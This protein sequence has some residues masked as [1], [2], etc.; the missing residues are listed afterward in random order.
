VGGLKVGVEPRSRPS[1][2]GTGCC[3]ST[4]V[5]KGTDFGVVTEADAVADELNDRPRK[6]LAFARPTEQL[7]DLLLQ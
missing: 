5:P 2:R 3:A 1:S 6:R 4:Y 7:A